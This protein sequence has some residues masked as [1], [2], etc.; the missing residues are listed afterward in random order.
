MIQRPRFDTGTILEAGGMDEGYILSPDHSMLPGAHRDMIKCSW[1]L[2]RFC[3]SNRIEHEIT[4]D[5]L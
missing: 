5:E 3:K 4:R 2:S 1:A